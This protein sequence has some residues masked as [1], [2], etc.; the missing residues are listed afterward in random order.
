MLYLRQRR[1]RPRGFPSWSW[2]Q[3]CLARSRSLLDLVRNY[4]ALIVGAGELTDAQTAQRCLDAG[5]KFLTGPGLDVGLALG[6]KEFA[7][8]DR[9]VIIPGALTPTEMCKGLEIRLRF[10][11][12]FSLR[13]SGRRPLHP[14]AQ[15]TLSEHTADRLRGSQSGNCGGVYYGWRHGPGDRRRLDPA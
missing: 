11:K 9:P 4:P 7:R 1:F 8:E 10:C 6:A 15:R 2:R 12:G 5:A 14:G 13:R 3:L